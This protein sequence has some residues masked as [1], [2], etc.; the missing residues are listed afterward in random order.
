MTYSTEQRNILLTF[1]QTNPDTVFSA[2]QIAQSLADKNISRSAVYRNL[3]QLESEQK[4]KRVVKN[5]SHEAYYQFYD[6]TACRN[7]IHL[8]CTKCGK[9]FHMEGNDA[10]RLSQMLNGN[11]GFE[12]NKS[13]TVIYGLCKE[14]K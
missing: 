2:K 13:E 12:L 8:S 7:H 6:I 3:A 5:G 11:E 14:C 10:D 4:I 9:I 1:L